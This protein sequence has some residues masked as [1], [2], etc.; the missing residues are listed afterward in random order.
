M[1]K[2]ENFERV[3]EV[4]V[5]MLGYAFMGKAHSQAY[6]DLPI[7]FFPQDE[8]ESDLFG[9]Q[10]VLVGGVM[11]LIKS[12]FEV[13]VES[14]YAPELAYFEASNGMKLIMDLVYK[15]GFSGMLRGVSDI[16][17][18][19]GLVEGPRIIDGHVRT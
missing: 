16:A 6:I 5:G 1:P 18:Y 15:G 11:E 19:R 2:M 10:A 14:G 13:L 17:K 9:E 3:P 7:F 12:G 8:T 4:G